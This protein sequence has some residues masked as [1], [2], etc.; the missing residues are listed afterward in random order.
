MAKVYVPEQ[1]FGAQLGDAPCDSA[2][3]WIPKSKVPNKAAILNAAVVTTTDRDGNEV[4]VSLAEE[5]GDYIVTAK[6]L[7]P[8]WDHKLEGIWR[9]DVTFSEAGFIDHAHIQPWSPSQ[10]KA[11]DAFSTQ[12]HGILNLACGKGKTVLGLKKIAQRNHPAL[13]IVNNTG[14]LDQWVRRAM[15]P[16]FLNLPKTSIGV[17]QGKKAQWGRP[18]VIAMIQ[19]L[20]NRVQE[21][22]LEVR[23]RFGTIIWD[24]AHR[25][26]APRFVTTAPVFYGARFGLTATPERADGL[27]QVY[28]AHLGEVFYSDMETDMP[29]RTFFKRLTTKVDMRNPE[30]LDVRG[31][32]SRGKFHIHLSNITRTIHIYIAIHTICITHHISINI[33]H[34]IHMYALF[35]SFVL[36]IILL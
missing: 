26:A 8:D 3:M 17:V 22:P 11:W 25:L 2:L 14:L 21:L 31:E 19:T 23:Q 36:C 30:I 13:V 4:R 29:A 1:D 27:E 7:F 16:K 10:A 33:H 15:D 24:E 32:F 34:H 28:M 18:L 35:V 20:C 9:P 6:H 5:V 12:K